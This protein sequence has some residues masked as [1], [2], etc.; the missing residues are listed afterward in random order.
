[1]AAAING[2]AGAGTAYIELSAAN[3]ATLTKNRVAATS[4]ATTLT[5]TS[6]GLLAA[7]ETLT[8]VT[9]SDIVVKCLAERRGAIDMVVQRFPELQINKVQ[10]KLGYNF[11][12][13]DL[14]GIKTF[15]E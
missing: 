3:R 10:D 1:M 13:Y 15:Q 11:I 7:T 8:N 14:Y 2:G 9:A 12:T 6:A 4:T 5:V